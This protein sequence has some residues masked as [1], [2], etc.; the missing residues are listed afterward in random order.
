MAKK[1]IS[2][3]LSEPLNG[4][5]SASFDIHTG[6]GNLTIDRLLSGEQLLAGGTVEYREDQDPPTPCVNTSH[7]RT[8][9]ALRA[10]GGWRPSLRMPWSAFNG[11]TN[12]Q[13]HLNPAVSS[14]NTAHSGGGN[15]KLDLVG[16]LVTRVCADSGG[17]N[18]DVV[19][20]TDV[21]NVDV[22]AKSGGGTVTVEIGKGTMGSSSVHAQSGA[23]KVTVYVPSGLAARIH[24]MTGMGKVIIDPRFN[25]IDRNTYQSPD[26]DNATDKV[27]I[28]LKSGAGNVSANS[29]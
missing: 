7:G 15:V 5:P 28:T 26:Y 27:E 9:F 4:I 1:M 6:T 29:K 17:G 24:A 14:D 3:N 18:L 11:E 22:V 19:L 8:T 16:M 25:Q 13:I 21:T 10:E 12:W 20:P 2:H 23:G